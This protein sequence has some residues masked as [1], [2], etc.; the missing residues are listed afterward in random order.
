MKK[1]IVKQHEDMLEKMEIINEDRWI[2]VHYWRGNHEKTAIFLKDTDK[3]IDHYFQEFYSENA[4]TFQMICEVN[5]FIRKQKDDLEYVL[6]VSSLHLSLGIM[7]ALACLAG[8]KLG[9]KLDVIY[10]IYP[11]FTLIGLFIGIGF[12]GF[13]GYKMIQKFLKPDM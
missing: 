10:G 7:F 5:K 2:Y 6:K 1:T 9:S 4:V 12:A 13:S 11:L 8:F 3:S